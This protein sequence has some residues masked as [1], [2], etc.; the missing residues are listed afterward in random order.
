MKRIVVIGAGPAG[1]MAAISSKTHHPDAQVILIDSNDKLAVKMRL[2]G[3]GRCNVSANVTS[4]E[5]IK[6]TTRNGRFLY[7][8]LNQFNPQNI[9]EFFESRNLKLKEEDH[10]RLFPI[11]NK[12][13]DIVNVLEKELKQLGV[14]ILLNTKVI[15]LDIEHHKIQTNAQDISFDACILATGGKTFIHTGSDGSG[16]E[17]L[18][19]IGHRITDLKPAEVALV[20]NDT[21]IQTKELQGLSFKDVKV[22]SYINGKKKTIIQNDLLI[23]HFGLSGP[24]ALQTSSYCVDDFDKGNEIIVKVDFV[25]HIALETLQHDSDL[26]KTLSKS[27]PKR[28]INFIQNNYPKNQITNIVKAFPI[29]IHDRRGFS[30]AFVTAGGVSLKEIDPK[31]MKSKRH[32]SLSVCGETLDINS[33]TGGYNI[34]IAMSTGYTAGKYCIE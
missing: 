9:I 25:P 16:F 33:L 1:C 7:S 20:S 24:A 17:L 13:D 5:I 12:A 27:C 32:P 3:G 15:N 2:S 14:D 26:I 30:T 28:L 31:T 18:K 10:H 6:N 23:T 34:T 22:T 11:T 8:S 21:F 19:S 4:D 29:N